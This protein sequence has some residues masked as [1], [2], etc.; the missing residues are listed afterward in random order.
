[1][2]RNVDFSI[3][4]LLIVAMLQS[5]IT[6]S[7]LKYCLVKKIKQILRVSVIQVFKQ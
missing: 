4:N 7:T 2:T 6:E 1:M 5:Y 3:Y